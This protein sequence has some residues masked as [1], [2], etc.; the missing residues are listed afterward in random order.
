MATAMPISRAAGKLL[1]ILLHFVQIML[2]ISSISILFTRDSFTPISADLFGADAPLMNSVWLDLLMRPVL[3][4]P[5]ALLLGGFL[6]L[7]YQAVS[8]HHKLALDVASTAAMAGWISILL[9]G[10]YAPVSL[11]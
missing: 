5:V 7:R 6:Y 10:L 11:G 8:K 3:A 1:L 9:L 2:A 4:I